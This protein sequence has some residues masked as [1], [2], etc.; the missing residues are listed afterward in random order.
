MFRRSVSFG[1][2]Q[3]SFVLPY[4][5]QGLLCLCAYVISWAFRTGVSYTDVTAS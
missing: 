4:M 3:A 1:G 2:V 5:L